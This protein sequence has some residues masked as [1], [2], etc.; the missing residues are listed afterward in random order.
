MKYSLSSWVLLFNMQGTLF[1]DGSDSDTERS[2]FTDVTMRQSDWLP[3]QHEQHN[4]IVSVTN[5]DAG[6]LVNP[7]RELSPRKGQ[8]TF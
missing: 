5:K 6:V 7:P 2:V 8:G 4:Q 3:A 1:A